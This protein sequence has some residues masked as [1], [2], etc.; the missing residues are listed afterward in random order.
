M[1]DTIVSQIHTSNV[2]IQAAI[3]FL[4]ILFIGFMV[5][6]YPIKWISHLFIKK[7]VKHFD[8]LLQKIDLPLIVLLGLIGFRSSLNIIGLNGYLRLINE[9]LI[10]VGLVYF[11]SALI[12]SIF[13]HLS[14]IASKT[15]SSVDDI[16]FPFISKIVRF[17][18]FLIAFLF[19]LKLWGYD[20]K[21]ALAGIGILGIALGFALQETLGNIFGGIALIL[22]KT[23]GIGDRLEYETGKVGVVEEVGI[24]TTRIRNFDNELLVI[25]NGSLANSR[26]INHSKPTK[27][28]RAVIE[29]GVAYGSDIDK[30][31]KIAISVAQKNELVLSDPAPSCVFLQMADF[32]L[33]MKL[34]AWVD[35]ID[36]KF[37]V[38][39][40]LT[41]ELYKALNKN[42][43]N[44]PFPTQTVYIKK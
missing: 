43:I 12:F 1:F 3:I 7:N 23:F 37:S 14:D 11:L 36:Q 34:F 38:K 35:T 16:L 42:K 15:K 39:E 30:V 20:I 40:S 24:R 25:P 8:E 10:I 4:G 9:T 44:I 5:I 19:V 6:K 29:F 17:I 13:R 22:D 21:S 2:Y 41:C 26:I 28:A 33:N 31:K 32:S 27:Q 18:L